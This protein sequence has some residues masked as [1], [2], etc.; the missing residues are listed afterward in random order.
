MEYKM[1]DAYANTYEGSTVN[2][3]CNIRYW[4]NILI[5]LKKH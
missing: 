5:R 4:S 1:D 3:K 2:L